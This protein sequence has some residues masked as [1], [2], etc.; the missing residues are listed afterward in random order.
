VSLGSPGV[1]AGPIVCGSD[2]HPIL[3]VPFAT[4]CPPRGQNLIVS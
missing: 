2:I 3:G 1:S 4:F